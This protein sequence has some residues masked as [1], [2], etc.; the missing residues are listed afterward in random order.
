MGRGMSVAL[1]M[2]QWGWWTPHF[3][4]P[5]SSLVK[6]L[7][8]SCVWDGVTLGILFNQLTPL[9]PLYHPLI[10]SAKPNACRLSW[11]TDS[12]SPSE[13]L[14][15][16]LA[17]IITVCQVEGREDSDLGTSWA[18]LK[19]RPGGRF[20]PIKNCS[21]LYTCVHFSLAL[22]ASKLER[23]DFLKGVI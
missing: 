2:C 18:S 9:P 13:L 6:K 1:T 8:K 11:R 23:K 7:R 21:F 22:L 12:P 19:S 3:T 15:F 14:R 16:Q 20:L 5:Y 10:T 17:S 4:F